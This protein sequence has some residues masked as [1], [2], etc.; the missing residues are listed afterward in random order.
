MARIMTTYMENETLKSFVEF[1]EEHPELRFWQA[2]FAWTGEDI[3]VGE[4]DP[5]YWKNK[6][7]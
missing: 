6:N 7:D 3:R 5:F 4:E 2:L 1:C